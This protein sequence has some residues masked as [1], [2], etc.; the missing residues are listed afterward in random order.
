MQ[1]Y[2]KVREKQILKRKQKN[3]CIT[4]K[5]MIYKGKQLQNPNTF[6]KD[7]PE[8]KGETNDNGDYFET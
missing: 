4:T 2:T 3:N 7:L 6:F 1:N 5:V 8:I